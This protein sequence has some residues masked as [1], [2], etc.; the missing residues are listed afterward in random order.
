MLNSLLENQNLDNKTSKAD[1]RKSTPTTFTYNDH[2]YISQRQWHLDTEDNLTNHNSSSLSSP[3]SPSPSLTTA[4]TSSSSS[5]ATSSINSFSRFDLRQR[6]SQIMSIRTESIVRHSPSISSSRKTKHRMSA[7][8]PVHPLIIEQQGNNLEC[9]ADKVLLK[10]SI[11]PVSP[12][13]IPLR[14]NKI[15]PSHPLM[16][17]SSPLLTSRPLVAPSSSQITTIAESPRLSWLPGLFHFKKP[18]VKTSF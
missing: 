14:N 16:C 5:L 15:R 3:K 12:S 4:E 10:H 1:K 17:D 18:K 7:P 13:P 8:V 2:H 11:S 6:L 9:S